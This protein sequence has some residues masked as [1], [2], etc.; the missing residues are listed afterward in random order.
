MGLWSHTTFKKRLQVVFSNFSSWMLV[1]WISAALL[2]NYFPHEDFSLNFPHIFAAPM[3]CTIQPTSLWGE[4]LKSDTCFSFILDLSL[5]KIWTFFVFSTQFVCV[6]DTHFH[7]DGDGEVALQ[8][9]NST[10]PKRFRESN[11][12]PDKSLSTELSQIKKTSVF[13]LPMYY[14]LNLWDMFQH[15]EWVESGLH[16]PAFQNKQGK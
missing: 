13:S 7:T 5:T 2:I 8:Y 15:L 12:F 4:C 14:A 6:E 3:S 11:V 1:I 16:L 10:S 9:I